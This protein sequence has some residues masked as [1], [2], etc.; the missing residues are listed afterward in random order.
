MGCRAD[1]V[2]CSLGEAQEAELQ[3]VGQQGGPA[4]GAGEL[5]ST[6]SQGATGTG[7]TV[8]SVAPEMGW[9]K[10]T[11]ASSRGAECSAHG[12]RKR[13]GSGATSIAEPT[14]WHLTRIGR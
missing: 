5:I 13:L 1:T 4:G 14:G 3:G 6:L 2:V 9:D 10:V 11:E 8:S 12:S 7:G